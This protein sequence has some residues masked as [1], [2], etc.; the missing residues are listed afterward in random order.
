MVSINLL[1]TL[2]DDILTGSVNKKALLS[3]IS[4]ST[5]WYNFRTGPNAKLIIFRVTSNAECFARWLS[6]PYAH[7]LAFISSIQVSRGPCC[8]CLPMS[9]FLN[10]IFVMFLGRQLFLVTVDFLL[11]M[12][13]SSFFDC[14]CSG[15]RIV[16]GRDRVLCLVPSFGSGIGNCFTVFKC[17]IFF[18]LWSKYG[19]RL[20]LELVPWASSTSRD[21]GLL[22]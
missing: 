14:R 16:T 1:L 13:L 2:S 18:L 6:N 22:L 8:R 4:F 15:S 3:Y 20:T 9:R 5:M 19:K 12:L 7:C 11:L 10:I 21:A 17:S